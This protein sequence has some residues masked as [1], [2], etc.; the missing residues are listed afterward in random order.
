MLRGTKLR[1]RVTYPD[2][3]DGT[4]EVEYL[5]IDADR[6]RLAI[7]TQLRTGKRIYVYRRNLEL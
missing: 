7:V 5:D 1:H 6:P 2:G 4:E 3:T